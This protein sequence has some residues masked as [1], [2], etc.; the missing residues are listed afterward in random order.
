MLKQDGH[1]T[2]HRAERRAVDH[3]RA[4][5]L[6]VRPFVSQVETFGQVVIHLDRSELPLAAD[7]IAH[8]EIQLRPVEG[9]L[10]EFDGRIQSLFGGRLDDRLFGLVPVFVRADVLL[11]VVRIAQ[12]HLCGKFIETQRLENI[13]HDVDHLHELVLQLVGTAKDVG[14]VLRKPAYPGQP[15][16][17]A[18]LFV[19][20][21]GAEFGETQ[22]QI[23]VRTRFEFVDF[24]VVRAV[25]RLEQKL[26]AVIRRMDRLERVFPVLGVMPRSNVQ[27]FHPDVRRDYL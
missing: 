27:V 23:F 10:T 1:E 18:A 9:G 25:H 12:R 14:V 8:H 7:R 26:L 13:Q 15:V 21:H 24:A 20:V 11:L 5:L 17:L 6:V 22:R 16:Q 2:L 4:M 19:A 3:D